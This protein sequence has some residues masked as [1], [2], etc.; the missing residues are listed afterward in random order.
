MDLKTFVYLESKTDKELFE[1]VAEINNPNLGDDS[2]LRIA[3]IEIFGRFDLT[4][5]LAILPICAYVL[6]QRLQTANDI[7]VDLLS[8][9]EYKDSL[10]GKG[11]V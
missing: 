2:S 8:D 3:C 1:L 6:S 11:L 10:H 5:V 9:I 4:F 7:I